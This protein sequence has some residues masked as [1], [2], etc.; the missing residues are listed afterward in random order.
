[1]ND[2]E[3]TEWLK[4]PGPL[5]EL[6]VQSMKLQKERAEKRLNYLVKK[7]LSG[8]RMSISEL[9]ELGA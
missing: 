4:G 7:E 1:M 3:R 5:L 8:K 2:K 6:Q 9:I